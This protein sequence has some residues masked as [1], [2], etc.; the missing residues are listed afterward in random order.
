MNRALPYRPLAALLLAVFLFAIVGK[1][2]H[3]H[4]GHCEDHSRH[5]EAHNHSVYFAK[6]HDHEACPLCLFHLSQ[7]TAPPPLP[8]FTLLAPPLQEN[9]RP[10]VIT[11]FV[12][13]SSVHLPAR[14]PPAFPA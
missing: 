1:E 2:L 14:A 3:Q 6:A 7:T 10:K 4:L 8:V 9:I 5:F 12:R 13:Q 11:C